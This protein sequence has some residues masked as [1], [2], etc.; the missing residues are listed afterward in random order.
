MKRFVAI[1]L[2]ALLTFNWVGYR[3]VTA[4]MEEQVN[5]ELEARLDNN[6]YNEEELI[7]V[8]V[9][10]QLP[11]QNDWKEFQRIDGEIRLGDVLYKYVKRKIEGGQ[12]VLL[13]L[14]NKAKMAVQT[15]RDR[16]FMLVNDLQHETGSK[17]GKVPAAKSLK[18]PLTEYFTQENNWAIAHLVA[19][20]QEYGPVPAND[21]CLSASILPPAQPPDAE[22]A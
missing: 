18:T 3:F 21:C 1:T 2:L 16:F 5:K 10:I 19:D 12:L 17:D 11:Y 13:C 6:D 22:R 7:E 4:W 20:L 8:R 15:S 14:P 9:P